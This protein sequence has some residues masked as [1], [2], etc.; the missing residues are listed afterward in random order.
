MVIKPNPRFYNYTSVFENLLKATNV[1]TTYPIVHCIITF[2]SSK[3]ITVT[4]RDEYEYYIRMYGL[5]TNEQ[6][7]EEKIGGNPAQYIK[8]FDVE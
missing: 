4:K 7:F 3:A 8:V 1:P 5:E 6:V 2:D